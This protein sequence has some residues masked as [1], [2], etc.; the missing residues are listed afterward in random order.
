MC[1]RRGGKPWSHILL[2]PGGSV[3]YSNE[4]PDKLSGWRAS[5][6]PGAAPA[7]WFPFPI[8]FLVWLLGKPVFQLHPLSNTRPS[9]LDPFHP[10]ACLLLA[11]RSL[12]WA[13]ST[14]AGLEAWALTLLAFCPFQCMRL[15]DV[16]RYCFILKWR[17][18][19]MMVSLACYVCPKSHV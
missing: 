18:W 4:G 8:A 19:T 1:S 16:G 10:E 3:R 14:G 15:S 11:R 6:F 12:L 7:N 13:P 9:V 17:R 2:M 5:L